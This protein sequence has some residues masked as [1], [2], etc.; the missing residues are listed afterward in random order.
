[1]FILKKIIWA[2]RQPSSETTVHRLPNKD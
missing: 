2:V 1:V